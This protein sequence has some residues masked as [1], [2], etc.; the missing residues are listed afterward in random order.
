MMYEVVRTQN[1]YI[2]RPPPAFHKGNCSDPHDCYVFNDYQKMADKLFELL[3]PNL[4][5][6]QRK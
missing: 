1:G 3:N 6:E 2:V 4:H 5:S